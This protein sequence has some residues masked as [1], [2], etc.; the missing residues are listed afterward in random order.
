LY[1]N[2]LQPDGLFP[3]IPI[4]H[5]TP[6]GGLRAGFQAADAQGIDEGRLPVFPRLRELKEF[7]LFRPLV[8][9]VFLFAL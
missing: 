2:N 7:A 5:A 6:Q 8:P 1:H 9:L 3:G 4:F